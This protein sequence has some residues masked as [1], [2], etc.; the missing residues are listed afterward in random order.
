MSCCSHSARQP[1]GQALDS[2][3]AK[4][5]SDDLSRYIGKKALDSGILKISVD[6]NAYRIGFDFNSVLRANPIKDPLTF[7]LAPFAILVKS[8]SDGSWSVSSDL[9]PNAFVDVEDR[10]GCGYP[11]GTELILWQKIVELSVIYSYFND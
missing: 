3:G 8:R 1:W 10:T 5:L 7:N 9:T 4:Q 2:Q 11:H 6:G